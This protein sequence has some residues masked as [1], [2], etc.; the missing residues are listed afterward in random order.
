MS[1]PRNT[2]PDR[3]D[4]LV[5]SAVRAAAAGETAGCPDADLLGLYAERE[6]HGDGH[7]RIEAHVHAC[8]RCQAVVAALARA[9]P[10]GAGVA[11]GVQDNGEAGGFM[12]WFAGWRWLV[13][14]ASLTAVALV[15]VWIGRGPADEVAE[16]ERMQSAAADM[17]GGVPGEPDASREMAFV[18]E[19]GPG[20]REPLHPAAPAATAPSTN[21]AAERR[22]TVD[23][24]GAPARPGQ[25]LARQTDARAR[26]EPAS[27]APA[28]APEVLG[29]TAEA[30]A[31]GARANTQAT[32]VADQPAE[33]RPATSDLTTER[34]ARQETVAAAK[35]VTDTRAGS[36]PAAPARA[37]ER[38]ASL[39]ETIT[40]T[41]ASPAF[42]AAAGP[43]AWRVTSGAVERTRD[44]GRTWRRVPTP[45]GLRVVAVS[46]PT[47]DV[48]WAV[49][50]DAVLRTTDG[51][52]WTRTA[53]PTTLPLT[54][55]VAT[56]ATS[57]SVSTA[58]S[59]R[60]G[61]SDGGLTWTPV[62]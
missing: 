53:R 40:V 8:G 7:A 54:G 55:V 37:D 43:V 22:A 46:S 32:V 2:V 59:A 1:V 45:A 62:P 33:A 57:A 56:S 48:C 25:R 34:D 28:G 9:L 49:A 38:A 4:P 47:P 26:T 29:R 61:T 39:A 50:A 23:G 18:G 15:A 6:L 12:A 36:A 27:P 30:P 60:F 44:D 21:P 41:E 51:A 3:A 35:A 20:V 17:S 16:T 10:E 11:A 13:P 5:A 14:A 24:S 19:R 58:S 52:T 42:R 31:G